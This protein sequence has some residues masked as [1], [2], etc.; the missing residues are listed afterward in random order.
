MSNDFTGVIASEYDLVDKVDNAS[1]IEREVARLTI[2]HTD[3][4]DIGTGTG[5]TVEA[6]LEA[7]PEE[8]ITTVDKEAEMVKQARKNLAGHKNVVIFHTDARTYL[9]RGINV[10]G[11]VSALTIHNF[12]QQYRYE[13]LVAAYNTLSQ[14]GIFINGDKI[15][16]P[17]EHDIQYA[18]RVN[19]FREGFKDHPALQQ[20]WLEHLATDNSPERILREEEHLRQLKEIGF[21]NVRL[22]YRRE[23]YAVVV[24]E[25]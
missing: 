3:L 4:I 10:D 5:K 9:R 11:I 14:G 15:A 16:H 7:N 18:I 22:I 12:T 20:K 2:G 24:C 21:K 8:H 19:L 6:V 17:T 1:D 13:T 25:K 23:M